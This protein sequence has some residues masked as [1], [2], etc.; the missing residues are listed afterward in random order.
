MV[1][2]DIGSGT[3]SGNSTTF[4]YINGWTDDTVWPGMDS[5]IPVDNTLMVGGGGE[6]NLMSHRGKLVEPLGSARMY[7]TTGSSIATCTYFYSLS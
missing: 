2:V 3:Q 4:E 6:C 7:T 1:I 5:W